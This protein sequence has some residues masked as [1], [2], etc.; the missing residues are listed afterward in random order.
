MQVLKLKKT[1]TSTIEISLNL[2]DSI[3]K[4]I[5]NLSNLEPLGISHQENIDKFDS[6]RVVEHMKWVFKLKTFR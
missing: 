5:K 3:D 2:K 1:S 4:T 6:K